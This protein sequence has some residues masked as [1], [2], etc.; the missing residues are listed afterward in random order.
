MTASSE[1][2]KSPESIIDE[3]DNEDNGVE[4]NPADG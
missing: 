2:T 3:L 1:Q 4:E